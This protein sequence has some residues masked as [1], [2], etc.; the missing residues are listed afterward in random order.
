[1]AGRLLDNEQRGC[2]RN[3]GVGRLGRM[4]PVPEQV[5]IR[6]LA[7]ERRDVWRDARSGG[8][9]Q[10]VGRRVGHDPVQ[11]GERVE[12]PD[13]DTGQAGELIQDSAQGAVEHLRQAGGQ[14]RHTGV[15]LVQ[16]PDSRRQSRQSTGLPSVFI[17]V[18]YQVNQDHAFLMSP[19]QVCSRRQHA[20][21]LPYQDHFSIHG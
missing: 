11:Q 5:F 18:V 6:L 4:N 13:R 3:D 15:D 16:C 2:R 21:L 17:C 20:G 14:L 7:E 19:V 8:I 10:I 1:M 9:A 12:T